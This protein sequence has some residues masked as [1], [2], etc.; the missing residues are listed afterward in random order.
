MTKN[1][2]TLKYFEYYRVTVI[3]EPLVHIGYYYVIEFCQD[4]CEEMNF[5]VALLAWFRFLNLVLDILN[6]ND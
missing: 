4:Y 2:G 5:C 6:P 3:A 1:S